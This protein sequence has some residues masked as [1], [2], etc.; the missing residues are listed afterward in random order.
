[1]LASDFIKYCSNNFEIF[2]FDKQ[3]LDITNITSIEKIITKI[4]PEIILN[5]AAYT[6][7]DDA[8][9]IL[10]KLNYDINTI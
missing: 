9:D 4:K 3:K 5:C 6:S 10:K 2:A 1:M 7:V 8:E